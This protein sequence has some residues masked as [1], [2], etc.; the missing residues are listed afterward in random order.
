M[1][2]DYQVLTSF[3]K[4]KTESPTSQSMAHLRQIG[5]KGWPRRFRIIGATLLMLSLIACTLYS[6]KYSLHLVHSTALPAPHNEGSTSL[7]DNQVDWSRFAYVQYVT[8]AQ[9]LCNSVMLFEILN[10]LGSKADRLMM[11][12]AHMH[13][14]PA[15]P[16]KESRLLLKAQKEYN[17]KLMPIEVQRRHR[18]KDRTY[19]LPAAKTRRAS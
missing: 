2:Q 16:S 18:T 19:Q 5:Q 7:V 6:R 3:S 10:R 4:N 15:S 17:V 12:P 9:Y 8:N 11:Y 13:P 1:A 14:D